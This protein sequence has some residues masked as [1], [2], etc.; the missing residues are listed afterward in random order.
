VSRL[1]DVR[2][3]WDASPCDGQS[4]YAS[5]ARIRYGKE[6]WLQPLLQKIASR[7][8]QVVEIG[9][10]QGT[11]G[12]TLCSFLPA[13]GSY[14][15]IDMSQASLDNARAAGDEVGLSLRVKPEFRLGN[16]ERLDFSDESL[17]CVISFGALH[18]TES[19]EKAIAEISRSLAPGG[20]AYICL[21]RT[22][23]P[24]LL[25]AHTLRGLQSGIDKLAHTDR[26]LYRL[27]RRLKSEALM[28]T[29]ISEC[30]GVPILRS[31]TRRQMRFLFRDFTLLR[32][33]C[34]GAGLPPLG[35]NRL[36]EAACGSTLGYLW[37]AELVK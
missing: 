23:A 6:P 26:S 25:V 12:V 5:R 16:A 30:F 34:H 9:C 31:Y 36:T 15:G 1:F 20:A 17:Q 29:A 21:Y 33:T 18:H 28:G 24:K 8:R 2:A 13:G 4:T 3:F 7:H 22:L 14:I 37:L 11:D 32:L 27:S 35:I 19:T 10:G